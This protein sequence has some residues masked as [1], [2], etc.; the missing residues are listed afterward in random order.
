M[1][2]HATRRMPASRPHR[3]THDSTTRRRSLR[4]VEPRY[5][6]PRLSMQQSALAFRDADDFVRGVSPLL[7][8]GAYEWLWAQP[9]IGRASCRERVQNSVARAAVKK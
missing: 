7:E 3:C 9:E 5:N 8:L 6:R 1:L 4:V 2:Q